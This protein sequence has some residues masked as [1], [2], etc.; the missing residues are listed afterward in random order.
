VEKFRYAKPPAGGLQFG[1]V[2]RE[3]ITVLNWIPLLNSG[4]HLVF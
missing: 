3:A 1:R 2:E 4:C